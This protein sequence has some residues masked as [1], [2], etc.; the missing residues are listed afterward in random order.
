MRKLSYKA[1][2]PRGFSVIKFTHAD[3]G[4]ACWKVFHQLAPKS[5]AKRIATVRRVGIANGA[6]VIVEYNHPPMTSLSACVW[7]LAD[8]KRGK[9]TDPAPFY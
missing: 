4:D 7:W 1:T 9:L 2:G 5:K 8:R 6:Y 3:S